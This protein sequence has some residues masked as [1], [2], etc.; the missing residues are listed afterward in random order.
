MGQV[1]L[2]PACSID[3]IYR[4]I[5]VF[6]QTR[7]NRQDVRVEND[8]LRRKA[9][10]IDQDIIRPR[11]DLYSS[12]IIVGLS[13]LIKSHYH[14]GS[15][16][17]HNLAGT[18]PEFIFTLLQRNRVYDTLSLQ[19]FQTGLNNRPLRRIYHDRQF[20]N[21]RF[22]SNQVQEFGHRS[23]RIDHPLIHVYIDHLRT[24]FNLLAGY[25]KCSFKIAAQDQFR[26]FRRSGNVGPLTH[27]HKNAF[28]GNRY[29]FKPTQAHV[30]VNLRN[31]SWRNT[32]SFFG[33]TANVLGGSPATTTYNIN[34]A[35][36]NEILHQVC[37]FMRH[38]IVCAK[39]IR[40]ACVRVGRNIAARLGRKLLNMGAHVFSTQRTVKTD[41]QWFGMDHRVQKSLSSLSAQRSSRS[42]RDG[43]RD[44][45][46]NFT[47]YNFFIFF[48]RENRG[49]SIQCVKNGLDQ[50]KIRAA[51][52][53]AAYLLIISIYKLIK[54]QRPVS[55]VVYVRRY[56]KRTVGWPNG[57]CHK[58]FPVRIG[59][60]KLID[61]LF[62][63]LSTFKTHFIV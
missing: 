34:K 7:S 4:I 11:T 49:L 56:R 54:S 60:H 50:Q 36:L 42:I 17:V 8:V 6:F 44:H 25:G 22:R 23:L 27:V 48:N 24:T 37:R 20:R 16:V 2:N 51:I 57:T 26:K 35:M 38:L 58:A 10:F 12:L 33:D 59:S 28:R 30:V 19:A 21:V 29:R 15:T 32:L 55:G 62:G 61:G 52:Y 1:F 47:T 13:L 9:Q 18:F 39:L 43:T 45:D 3:K 5:I 53:Q 63:D 46:L 14:H 31:L 40:Q 41:A